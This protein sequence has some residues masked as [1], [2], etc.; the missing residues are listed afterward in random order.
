M[1]DA[2]LILA[3]LLSGAALL[4][5]GSP[6]DDLGA[7][8]AQGKDLMAAGRYAEAVPVYRE[9]VKAMPEDPGL[10]LN[11]GMALHLA[12]QDREALPELQA[13]HG[14]LPDS[15]PAAL[16]LGST[17]L[18]LGRTAEAVLPLQ[19][20]VRLQPD[21]RDALSMLVEALLGLERYAQAEP[22]LVQLSRLA[23]RDP[24]TWFNLGRTH[25]ELAGQAFRD[26]LKQDPVSSF[27]L[28]LVAEA[29]VKQDRRN[30][31]FHLY[32]QALERGP[33]IRGL[34]AAVAGIYRSVGQPEWAAA[35]EERERR[36][37][38]PD[39]SRATLECRFSAGKYAEVVGAASRS[40]TAEAYYWLARAHDELAAQAFARLEALP[41]SALS[42]EWK[43]Q[44]H[45]NEG[46]FPEACEEWRRAITLAPAEPRL[47]MEMAVTLRLNHD[48]AEAQR[49]LEEVVRA[50]PAAAE[51]SYLLGDVLLAQQQ[52]ERAIPFLEKAVRLAPQQAHAQA[53]LGRA[54]ALM[55]RAAEAVPHLKQGLSADE[56]GSVRY[57]LARAFQAAG[58]GEQARS[59][60]KDY[61]EF[62]KAAEADPSGQ[63]PITPP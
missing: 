2:R 41:P 19:K 22:H 52:P 61:E 49:V 53:A 23:P 54:Y 55:G 38:A 13:A 29:R 59:A 47:K 15:L 51:P 37:P 21:H 48:F 6:Q 7:K 16:F 20:A 34:H 40:K 1:H 31:A 45:R 27:A 50:Q 32:R 43:A 30:A 11:L 57:Q 35:E 36:V 33:T 8:S 26:L 42:H 5:P 24:A 62:R 25:E 44:S 12:G 14:L 28:A 58:E 9:L 60:L 56:D 10:L 3:F 18:R 39:C 46:R 4:R 17:C 63:A